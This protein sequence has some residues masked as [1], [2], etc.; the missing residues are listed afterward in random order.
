MMNRSNVLHFSCAAIAAAILCVAIGCTAPPAT[1]DAVASAAQPLG[2]V[3]IKFK[4]RPASP[5]SDLFLAELGR[6]CGCKAAWSHALTDDTHVYFL[7]GP[8]TAATLA[9]AIA[10]IQRRD[11]VTY[12][13]QDGRVRT[14]T[15]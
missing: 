3:I 14:Q 4:V 6:D 5:G 13:E 9:D 10:N 12:A 15:Q 11:D 7:S 8:G 2:R 1:P